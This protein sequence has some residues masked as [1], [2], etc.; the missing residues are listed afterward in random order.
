VATGSYRSCWSDVR[1][2]RGLMSPPQRVLGITLVQGGVCSDGGGCNNHSTCA[3]SSLEASQPYTSFCNESTSSFPPTEILRKGSDA[4]D[5]VATVGIDSA[6]GRG[7]TCSWQTMIDC[8][9]RDHDCDFLHIIYCRQAGSCRC[10]RVGD[11]TPTAFARSEVV[12][13]QIPTA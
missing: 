10:E 9:A 4:Q 3:L 13:N 5:G 7:I 1:G 6:P 12:L 2:R 11:K 8:T